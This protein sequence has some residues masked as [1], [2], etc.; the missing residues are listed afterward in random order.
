DLPAAV[1]RG[2]AILERTSSAQF[3]AKGGCAACHA[4]NIMDLT[5][6]TLRS[7]G[8]RLDE[9]E[10]ASRL[11]VTKGR[12]VGSVPHLLER[13]DVAGT[14]DVPLFSIAAL[15]AIGYAPDRTTDAMTVNIAAQQYPDGRWHA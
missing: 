15:A 1:V 2:A 8:I 6:A 3:L 9:K 5:A 11:A 12:F 13:L 4:Q 7:K 10:A 14:P